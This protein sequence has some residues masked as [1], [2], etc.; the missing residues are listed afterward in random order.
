[1]TMKLWRT[2]GGALLKNGSG[3]LIKCEECPCGADV[4]PSCCVSLAATATMTFTV[5][6]L[7][8]A[9]LNMSRLGSGYDGLRICDVGD[10]H[11]LVYIQGSIFCFS[12]AGYWVFQFAISVYIDG[13]LDNYVVWNYT[14]F[15]GA[16][17]GDLSIA[18]SPF[19]LHLEG[20]NTEGVSGGTNPRT[21]GGV[22]YPFATAGGLAGVFDIVN[23]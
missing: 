5:G 4:I 16:A 15:I 13:V 22:N 2:A 10:G 12:A 14:V 17:A 11:T 9:T 8:P 23:P 3:A 1:M 6:A 19:H 20:N 7:A 18:C 21:C